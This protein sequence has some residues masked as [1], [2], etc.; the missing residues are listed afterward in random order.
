[1]QNTFSILFTCVGRRVELVEAFRNA[2]RTL[3]I[4]LCIVGI[5]YSPL[6]PAQYFCDYHEKVGKISDESYIDSIFE[7]CQKYN[8]DLIIPTIDTDL[9]ILSENKRYFEKHDIKVLI[10]SINKINICRDKRKTYKFFVENNLL[11]PN[12][13]DKIENYQMDFPCFVKPKDGS[14][15]INTYKVN[16]LDDLHSI[17]KIVPDYI[18]QPFIKGKEYTVD[19]MCDYDGNLISITPRERIKVRG[20]EVIITKIIKDL[21]IEKECLKIINKFK[22]CGPLT[23]QLIRDDKNRDFYI[24]INP[25]FGGGS[26]ASFASGANSPKALLACL[27]DIKYT[28]NSIDECFYSRFDETIRIG[29]K[30]NHSINCYSSTFYQLIRNYKVILF[31]LDDTLYNEKEYVYSGFK[32]V[33][34]N[35]SLFKDSYSFLKNS[36]DD[37]RKPFDELFKI[38]KLDDVKLFNEVLKTYQNHKP[39]IKLDNDTKEMLKLLKSQG[40]KLGLITDGR[41]NGQENKI[42]SLGLERFFDEL[43][44]T[45]SLAGRFGNPL[46]FRKPNRIAFEIM[47]NRFNVEYS[48]MVYVG[49]NY[50]K[51]SKAPFQ[52]GMDYIYYKNKEGLYFNE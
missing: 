52:L 41:V 11:A 31:D 10:S 28:N 47:K 40:F 6:S 1:M 34:N 33:C 45:D 38:M 42:D 3:N 32:A 17:V 36:F 39:S 49:D 50:K 5:D 20:G 16:S 2:G 26:P 44:I 35:F 51:D 24:E 8:I 22:P 19:I 7:L 48:E 14:S 29:S 4:N 18:I 21:Q 9:K 46:H 15:S 23:V 25:R 12:T 30:S 43:I 13:V 27:C 37:K